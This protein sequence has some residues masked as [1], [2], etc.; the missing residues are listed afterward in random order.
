MTKS[1]IQTN[2]NFQFLSA[3]NYNCLSLIILCIV[4]LVSVLI[5]HLATNIGIL[6][7]LNKNKS[8]FASKIIIAVSRY[9]C[10]VTEAWCCTVAAM[11]IST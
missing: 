2:L 6:E 7:R 11:Y 5:F 9:V 4:G 8:C 3:M 10:I 1:L